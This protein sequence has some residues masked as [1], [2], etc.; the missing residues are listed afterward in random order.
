MAGG[1]ISANLRLHDARAAVHGAK[2]VIAQASLL[3][4]FV[5]ISISALSTCSRCSLARP[6]PLR[7]A[8]VGREDA[9]GLSSVWRG[10]DE[11]VLRVCVYACMHSIL[12]V[13][14]FITHRPGALVVVESRLA[15]G[16]A[17]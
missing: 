6:L 9:P 12:F 8:F 14:N 5:S 16:A 3:S 10:T 17:A 15:L 7:P 2:R 4:N 13:R 11:V 1:A